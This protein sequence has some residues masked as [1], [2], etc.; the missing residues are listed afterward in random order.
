LDAALIAIRS[1]GGQLAHNSRD[2]LC[3]TGR[4]RLRSISG[5][6]D[7]EVAVVV[8]SLLRLDLIQDASEILTEYLVSERHRDRPPTRL[9]ARAID[10]TMAGNLVRPP[11]TVKGSRVFS[12]IVGDA[13][14]V[15]QKA[16]TAGDLRWT[17]QTE[18]PDFRL[19]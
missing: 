19:E 14:K 2:A 9:L 4:D 7:F 13:D 17:D 1:G 18:S 15:G 8:E 16:L 3:R 5:I 6:R 12:P 11:K 10:S